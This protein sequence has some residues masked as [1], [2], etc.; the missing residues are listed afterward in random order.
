MAT[1]AL[2]DIDRATVF[3]GDNVVFKNLSLTIRQGEQVAIVGPNGAGKSTLLKLVNRE[4]YPAHEDGRTSVRILGRETWNVWE[5]R[6]QIG[7]V[8]D[9]LRER[10]PMRATALDVALS[11]F[12]SSIGTQGLLQRDIT[13]EQ[14]SRAHRTLAAFGVAEFSSTPLSRLSTGERRRCLLARAMVH[15]P[16]TLVLD[17]PM[18]GLDVAARF[19]YLA[20]VRD[21]IATG[22]NIVLVT[23]HLNEI[24]PEV[25][26]V[27]LLRD[28][29]IVADGAKSAVLTEALLAETFGVTLKLHAM[30]GYYFVYPA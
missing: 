20:R 14:L 19:D 26:R 22:T 15:E 25:E 27:I 17:E 29:R 9:D 16:T 30:D 4:L 11:G 28:G 24:P 3:R 23:H 10:Y 8:S 6:R 5:L 1:T 12:F 13:D 7:L 18:A 2:I 21:M